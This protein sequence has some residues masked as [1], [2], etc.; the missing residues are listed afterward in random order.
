MMEEWATLPDRRRVK[1][2]HAITVPRTRI[3]VDGCVI[4]VLLSF[5][6]KETSEPG[7]L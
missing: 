4:I 7:D 5:S 3:R 1:S 2:K 6:E